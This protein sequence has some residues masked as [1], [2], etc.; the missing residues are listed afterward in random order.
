MLPSRLVAGLAMMSSASAVADGQAHWLWEVTTD[1]GDALVEPG[2]TAT[3]TMS[4]DMLPDVNYPDGPVLMFGGAVFDTLGNSSATKGMIA[5]WTFP[6]EELIFIGGDLTRTYGT[7]LFNTSI[8]QAPFLDFFIPDDPLAAVQFEWTT[9]DFSGYT[10][11]YTTD[12]T[13][14]EG[15]PPFIAVWE[16][17]NVNFAKD[18]HWPITEA[19]ISFQV[20]PGPSVASAAV[21]FGLGA[22]CRR[23]RSAP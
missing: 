13:P 3:V 7:S 22:G 14:I 2:E 20:V 21:V 1:N 17:T 18:V 8:G 11:N 10:V 5:G 23:R 16:G 6:T 19:E 15:E 4:I 12:T 9:E